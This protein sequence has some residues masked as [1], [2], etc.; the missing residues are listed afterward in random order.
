MFKL[1]WVLLLVLLFMPIAQ[2]QEPDDPLQDFRDKVQAAPESMRA[3]FPL[4]YHLPAP[5]SAQP[6]FIGEYQLLKSGLVNLEALTV[7]LPLYR[8]QMAG[9]E[10]VWYIITDTS[11]AGKAAEMGI[12]YSAKLTNADVGI[13]VRP[14]VLNPDGRVTF[15]RGS[16]DFSPERVLVAGTAPDSFPPVQFQPGAVGDVFYSPLMKIGGVIYNAPIVAFGVEADSL[17]FCT[18]GVDYTRVHDNVVAIC[19]A[20]GTVTLRL[21]SGFSFSRPVFY[22]STDSNDELTATLEGAIFAP[23]L[24]DIAVQDTSPFK[25]TESLYT[26]V[27]GP[28]GIGNPQRQGLTSVLNGEGG[29]LNVVGGIPTL[30]TE[31][32]PLWAVTPAVWT[33][34]AID[35]GYRSRLT[36]EFQILGFAAQGWLVGPNDEIFGYS[37]VIVNCPIVYRLL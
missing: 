13:T 6:E 29:A 8:G 16:V 30:S 1:Y 11:N 12:N 9:G 18:G 36:D 15:E 17:E 20:E 37:G 21:A 7:T 23:A 4:Q 25:A 31:Y 24:Q 27:N 19:P 35:L 34:E 28:T 22:I 5:S 26:F 3:D 2:A 33:Q 14:A 10:I 32:S